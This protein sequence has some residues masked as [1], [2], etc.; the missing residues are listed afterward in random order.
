[1]P[2]IT[3]NKIYKIISKIGL[4]EPKVLDAAFKTA[5]DELKIYLWNPG[6]KL[7]FYDELEMIIYK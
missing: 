4:I 1:M 6:Q 5:K 2:V 3:D 7:V